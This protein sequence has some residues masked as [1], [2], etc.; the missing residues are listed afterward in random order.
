MTNN[1]ITT[2]IKTAANVQVIRIATL[3]DADGRPSGYR[4]FA[5]VNGEWV[6]NENGY[7]TRSEALA[8]GQRVAK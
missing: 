6:G 7:R 1:N 2:A 3:V 5:S 8:V 4:F